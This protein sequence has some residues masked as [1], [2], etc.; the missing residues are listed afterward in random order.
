MP[1]NNLFEYLRHLGK[2]KD[3]P[4]IKRYLKSPFFK[5]KG[6]EKVIELFELLIRNPNYYKDKPEV[7]NASLNEKMDISFVG[8]LKS[9]L[10]K[11][12]EDYLRIKRVEEN[13]HWSK[14]IM[15]WINLD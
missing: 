9:T 8:N 1:R 15:S 14:Q 12:I 4:E 10:V 3:F 13:E 11:C 7:S 6:R 2:K 5:V